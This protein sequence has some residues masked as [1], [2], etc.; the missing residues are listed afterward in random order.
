MSEALQLGLHRTS[1]QYQFPLQHISLSICCKHS[2]TPS[3][4]PYK[5]P[6]RISAATVAPAARLDGCR[7]SFSPPLASLPGS[8]SRRLDSL[9]NIEI[10]KLGVWDDRA[11][12]GGAVHEKGLRPVGSPVWEAESSSREMPEADSWREGH[13]LQCS[14]AN[15]CDPGV[16][17]LL[18]FG[19]EG[20]QAVAVLCRHTWAC[21]SYISVMTDSGV[22][23][24]VSV[25]YASG[26]HLRIERPPTLLDWVN[27]ALAPSHMLQHPSRRG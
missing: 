3:T 18:S 24:R 11:R 13:R 12:C 10:Q 14:G 8:S 27:R 9:G 23:I 19:C 22:C 2:A 16:G 15:R 6:R 4:T 25:G 7:S 5:S 1:T 26:M 21:A 20:T 17:L